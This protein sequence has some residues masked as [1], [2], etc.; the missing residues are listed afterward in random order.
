MLLCVASS[1]P[2]GWQSPAVGFFEHLAPASWT[3]SKISNV[4]V[5]MSSTGEGNIY[6]SNKRSTINSKMLLL[7]RWHCQWSIPRRPSATCA[8]VCGNETTYRSGFCVLLHHSKGVA[9]FTLFLAAGVKRA[10]PPIVSTPTFPLH[11]ELLRGNGPEMKRKL[12]EVSSRNRTTS[13]P[14]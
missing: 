13:D 12:C 14:S 5:S 10:A 8:D 2:T 6:C 4:E 7:C 3:S 1:G 9:G 11:R